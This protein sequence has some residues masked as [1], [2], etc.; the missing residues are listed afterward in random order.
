[1]VISPSWERIIISPPVPDGTSEDDDIF[2][3]L[4]GGAC[5]HSRKRLPIFCE[6]RIH[7]WYIYS[8]LPRE[9]IKCSKYRNSM[10]CRFPDHVNQ[11]LP[12]R[13]ETCCKRPASLRTY[14]TQRES[15]EEAKGQGQKVAGI[16]LPRNPKF[17]IKHDKI[18]FGHHPKNIYKYQQK[19]SQEVYSLEDLSRDEIFARW[20]I[21]KFSQVSPSF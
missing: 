13:Q 7:V 19:Q 14:L 1:M 3:F 20:Y 18:D 11:I 8:H 9:S 17:N 6:V 5:D 15:W 4:F 16:T 10:E 12:Q 21:K 2:F